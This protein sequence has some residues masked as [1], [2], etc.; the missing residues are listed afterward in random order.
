MD[1]YKT[2]SKF[3]T[4]LEDLNARHYNLITRSTLPVIQTGYRGS[5]GCGDLWI[6]LARRAEPAVVCSSCQSYLI[7]TP[8]LQLCKHDL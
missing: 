8:R 2:L 1:R 6:L 7:L 5:R 3:E 4:E